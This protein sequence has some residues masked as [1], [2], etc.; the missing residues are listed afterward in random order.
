MFPCLLLKTLLQFNFY[1]IMFHLGAAGSLLRYMNNSLRQAFLRVNQICTDAEN[2]LKLSIWPL[3][4]LMRLICRKFS[5]ASLALLIKYP[6]FDFLN[7]Q[8]E[9]ARSSTGAKEIKTF[10]FFL[11]LRDR[12]R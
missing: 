4:Y 7:E 6:E 12:I 1:F 9:K 8:I 11:D 10:D 5:Y 3:S 2:P